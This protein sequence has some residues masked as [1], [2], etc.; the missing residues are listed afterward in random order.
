[1]IF[2]KK[3][4]IPLREVPKRVQNLTRE[5]LILWGDTV[6]MQTGASFDAW[7]FRNAPVQDAVLAAET[8]AAIL[9]ELQLREKVAV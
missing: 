8:L 2:K 4:E 6:L 5:E 3:E 1:M 7:R 9:T